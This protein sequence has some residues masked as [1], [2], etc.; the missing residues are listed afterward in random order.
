MIDPAKKKYIN[1]RLGKASE[2]LNDAKLL[3]YNKR[4]NSC[5][6]RLYYASFYAIIAL[7]L[8]DNFDGQTHE[9]TRNQFN[10]KYIKE[11]KID[12]ESGK[13]FSKLFD[14]R[15][16][17]DYGD[18]FDFTEDQILPLIEPVEALLIEIKKLINS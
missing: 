6:N 5:V 11:G 16:K 18:L 15:H 1:Y 4:W 12:K 13:L 14:W 3:A 7:L 9:G 10:L 17:G 2:S 8:S